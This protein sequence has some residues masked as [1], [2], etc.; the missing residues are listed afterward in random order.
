M[1]SDND[2][3]QEKKSLDIWYKIA[4]IIKN[5]ESG[6]LL[7]IILSALIFIPFKILSYGWTPSDDANRHVAFSTI[8]AKWSDIL[9]IDDKYDTDHNA[10]WHQILRFLHK[11][12]GFAKE[13]LMFFSVAG[14]FLLLNICGII[15]SPSPIS[16][17]VV[18]LMMLN[19]DGSIAYRMIMG[20]PFLFSCATTLVILYLWSFNSYEKRKP[21]Q[22]IIWL[23]YLITLTS[24]SLSVWIHGSWYLFLIIPISF[25][26]AGKTEDSLKL[27]AC[28]ILSTVI[29]A[30]LTGD[31]TNFLYFQFFATFS[32]FSEPTFNWLLVGEFA[33]G[34]QPVNWGLWVATIIFLS[35]K[36]C[37]YKLKDIGNDPVF[38]MILLSWMGSIWV[39]RFWLDWGRIALML[40]LSYKIYDIIKSSC[41]LNNPRIRY[42]L[43]LFVIICLVL[44][45]VNDSEGRYTK[46]AMI[47]PIDFYSEQTLDKLKGWE[48]GDGGIVYST[49]MEC[50]YQHFYMYPSAKWKY[51]LG[52]EPAIMKQED[53]QTMRDIDYTGMEESYSPWVKKMTEKDR[54]ILR[55]K[56][57]TFPELE[58]KKGNRTWWIGR[59]KKEKDK[60]ETKSESKL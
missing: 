33:A 14:L 56:L 25:F 20:R 26:I 54:L 51:I 48:P 28:I 38:I 40:W 39:Y 18:L 19:I 47:Q 50:F 57:Y 10:G 32:I 7:L 43:S 15:T 35:I 55:T 24:L 8:D 4:N 5:R 46:A 22:K 36:K 58:W 41:S 45:F 31:F 13:D 6:I 60:E 44:C 49:R 9:I 59:L 34:Y 16:W 42:C 1:M 23:K 3:N 53:R 27:T 11:H 17:C 30:F 21:S 12:C 37:N 2:S 29:G 52:F